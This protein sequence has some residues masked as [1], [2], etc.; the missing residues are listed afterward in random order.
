MGNTIKPISFQEICEKNK[1]SIPDAV[2][3]TI[4]KLII[5]YFDIKTKSSTVPVWEIVEKSPFNEE[6]FVE[7]QWY[8][9]SY[10]YEKVGWDVQLYAPSCNDDFDSFY[11]F[12][13]K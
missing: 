1:T 13:Q 4:N 8:D 9:F 7:N 10:L 6:Q 12:T 11:Y 5:K 3:K 2:V